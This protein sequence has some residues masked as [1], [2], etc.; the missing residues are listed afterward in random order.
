MW[1]LKGACWRGEELAPNHSLGRQQKQDENE[2]GSLPMWWLCLFHCTRLPPEAVP[3]PVLPGAKQVKRFAANSDPNPDSFRS[4]ELTSSN[5]LL[6]TIVC[7]RCCDCHL[8]PIAGEK[9]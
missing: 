2:N 1:R 4:L 8:P 3:G 9:N 6:E 7:S 5:S